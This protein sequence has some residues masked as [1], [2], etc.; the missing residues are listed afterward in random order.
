MGGWSIALAEDVSQEIV[1]QRDENL[2]L[3]NEGVSCNSGYGNNFAAGIT[4]NVTPDSFRKTHSLRDNDGC[5][6]SGERFSLRLL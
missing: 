2:I 5:A 1:K 4:I 6:K 3:S